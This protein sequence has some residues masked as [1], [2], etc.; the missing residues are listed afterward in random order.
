MG[1]SKGKFQ[2]KV[3]DQRELKQICLRLDLEFESGL[4]ECEKLLRMLLVSLLSK[5]HW[6]LVKGR[7]G[8]PEY[9]Q[10]VQLLSLFAERLNEDG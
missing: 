10:S 2:N 9:Y 5:T 1:T 3:L 8:L 6:G 7:I 4:I